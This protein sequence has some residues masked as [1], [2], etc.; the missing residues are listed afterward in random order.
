[1]AMSESDLKNE[2]KSEFQDIATTLGLPVLNSTQ[3]DLFCQAIA[4]AVVNHIRTNAQA[5]GTTVVSSGSSAGSWPT[6]VP[7]GGIT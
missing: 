2:L 4:D 6:T 1:M 3:L 7:P 5:T